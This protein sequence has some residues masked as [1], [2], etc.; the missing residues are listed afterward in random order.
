LKKVREFKILEEKI[1]R[2]EVEEIKK[3]LAE[4]VKAKVKKEEEKR[5]EAGAKMGVNIP[6]PKADKQKSNL[7]SGMLK[8]KNKDISDRGEEIVNTKEKL[9]LYFSQ[10]VQLNFT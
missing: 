6:M 7:F 5:E 9:T 1:K 4:E 10:I 3:R 8:V 2:A